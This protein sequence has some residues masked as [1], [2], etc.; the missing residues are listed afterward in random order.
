[1]RKSL[2]NAMQAVFVLALLS[3]GSYGLYGYWERQATERAANSV[4]GHIPCDG[5]GILSNCDWSAMTTTPVEVDYAEVWIHTILSVVAILVVL[6][7]IAYAFYSST[8]YE[9]RGENSKMQA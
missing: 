2:L 4:Q 6:G 8:R 3:A 7:A 1:M 5:D 9:P